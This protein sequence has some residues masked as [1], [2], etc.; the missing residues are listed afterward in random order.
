MET[1]EQGI[2]HLPM[3]PMI[4]LDRSESGLSD[5]EFDELSSLVHDYP[6]F[7][8]PDDPRYQRWEVL[9]KKADHRE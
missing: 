7:S 5:A 4:P 3:I 2:E 9:Q 6:T 8:G 1:Q